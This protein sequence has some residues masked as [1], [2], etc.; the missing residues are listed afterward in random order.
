MGA[1]AALGPHDR[2]VW[3]GIAGSK[4]TAGIRGIPERTVFHEGDEGGGKP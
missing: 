4:S 3:S 1:M 2:S